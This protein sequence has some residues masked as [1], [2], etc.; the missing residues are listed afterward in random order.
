M[1]LARGVIGRALRHVA[2]YPAK[3]S[4]N[5]WEIKLNALIGAYITSIRV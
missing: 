5:A 1:P 4:Q 2:D 3:V